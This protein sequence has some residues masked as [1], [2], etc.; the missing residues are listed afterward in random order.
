[1]VLEYL[2]GSQIDITSLSIQES[3]P[4]PPELK[5]D[6]ETEITERDWRYLNETLEHFAKPEFES[7]DLADRIMKIYLLSPSR[8]AKRMEE[9]GLLDK[10]P[11]IIAGQQ[12]KAAKGLNQDH[13]TD[14]LSLSIARKVLPGGNSLF[15][16]SGP[17]AFEAAMR[18]ASWQKEDQWDRYCRTIAY[19]AMAFPKKRHEI[20]VDE[21]FKE[22]MLLRMKLGESDANYWLKVFN[23]AMRIAVLFPE[24][25]VKQYFSDKDWE[26]A[27]KRLDVYRQDLG[28]TNIDF[29]TLSSDMQIVAA[30]EVKLSDKGLEI[31][32]R[33]AQTG[34]ADHE[35]MPEGRQF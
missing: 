29:L 34:I 18:V 20:G 14:Y 35:K 32:M 24:A 27:K 21:A 8:V 7:P 26:E 4:Q 17:Q 30:E 33:K 5:F 22:Q 11:Y 6:P 16:E 28:I 3:A 12:E 10:I 31:N 19:T 9:L 15:E 13:V 25:N 2:N 23:R 1:M